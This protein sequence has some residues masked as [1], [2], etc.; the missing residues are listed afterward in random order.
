ML[1]LHHE[2]QCIVS[3]LGYTLLQLPEFVFA[4]YVCFKRHLS[5]Q[6]IK[7]KNEAE[8]NNDHT[9]HQGQ[10]HYLKNTNEELK[11]HAAIWERPELKS[12]RKNT[13]V[14]NTEN[15]TCVDIGKV[16][17]MIL[18]MENRINSRIDKDI[19]QT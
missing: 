11:N 9:G 7:D 19:K 1:N 2:Y 16:K 4:A 13:V 14:A 17:Q 6:G 10:G 18:E 3:F 8:S 12:R 15:Y 5:R